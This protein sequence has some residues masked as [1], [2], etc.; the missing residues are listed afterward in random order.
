MPAP[1][2]AATRRPSA[3]PVDGAALERVGDRLAAAAEPPWLHAEVARRM[4]QRLPVIRTQPDTVL[5][6]WSRTGASTELL[7]RTYPKARLIEVDRRPR[8]AERSP[9]WKGWRSV[10]PG[11]A[12]EAV[13]PG[14]A[15]LLWAGMMLHWTADP[16]AEIQRWQAALAVDGFLMFS[17]FGPGTLEGLRALYAKAGWP[18]PHAAFVD[19]HDLGDMLL[20]A[21]FADPVMDQETLRLHWS[22]GDAMLREVRSLGGNVDPGRFAGLRTP[23]WRSRL[24]A[25]LEADGARPAMDFEV[26]YGHAFKAAPRPRAKASTEVSLQ[27]MRSILGGQRK[28]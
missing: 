26:V 10:A 5:D 21:G 17:T 13:E 6:W 9:W 27:D 11:C 1:A 4:A 23:R 2:A 22:G 20:H 7:R 15:G 18:V 8:A 12:P 28:R 16:L 14:R 25:L 24:V 19:M 3:R